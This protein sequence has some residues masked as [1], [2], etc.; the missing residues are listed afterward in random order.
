[1]HGD[2]WNLSHLTTRSLYMQL[3]PFM[4]RL[5]VTGDPW[6][7]HE[8]ITA[9]AASTERLGSKWWQRGGD[10]NLLTLQI[11]YLIYS[12]P[13]FLALLCWHFLLSFIQPFSFLSHYY[14]SILP[15]F[16]LLSF[17]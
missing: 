10:R 12:S 2:R 8:L 3:V 9:T 14:L 4:S 5:H 7:Q 17:I 6:L 1:V 15:L 13:L 11:H 16:S